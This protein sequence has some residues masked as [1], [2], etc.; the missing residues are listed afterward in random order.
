MSH[1]PVSDDVKKIS[2]KERNARVMER[3]L[4]EN[5]L[6]YQNIFQAGNGGISYGGC[7]Y[8]AG[9]IT[10]SCHTTSGN[11][12]KSA[13]PKK[14]TLSYFQKIPTK[15]LYTQVYY[16]SVNVPNTNN[17]NLQEDNR[18]VVKFP[19]FVSKGKR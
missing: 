17:E 9:T 6:G 10:L 1:G 14:V 13:Q 15:S 8:A 11:N 18:V 5:H 16:A 7:D 3:K 19:N 12:A 4:M 2:L